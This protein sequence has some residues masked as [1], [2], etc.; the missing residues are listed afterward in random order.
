MYCRVYHVLP[1]HLL[2]TL[3]HTSRYIL[4]HQP[5]SHE[6]KAKT[7][8]FLVLDFNLPFTVRVC[9]FIANGVQL[10]FHPST[11]DSNVVRDTRDIVDSSP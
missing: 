4:A 1:F 5:G 3:V 6:S 9:I 10:S 8:V 7:G 11:L 2:W